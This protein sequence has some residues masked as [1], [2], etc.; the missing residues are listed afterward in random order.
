MK[1]ILFILCLV[2]NISLLAQI[3]TAQALL[4]KLDSELVLNPGVYSGNLIYRDG[5]VDRLTR[6]VKL[7]TNDDKYLWEIKK[8]GENY[9]RFLTDP[10]KEKVYYTKIPP[11]I[12]A[13]PSP[14]EFDEN[15]LSSN[16]SVFDFSAFSFEANFKSEKIFE[17]KPGKV[18][19]WK[20]IAKPIKNFK[21]SRV[22]FLFT[23]SN[24]KIYRMDFFNTNGILNKTVKYKEKDLGQHGKKFIWERESTDPVTGKITILEFTHVAEDP[25]V[26]I[27]LFKKESL[28]RP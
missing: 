17:Y 16:F 12:V 7:Y 8:K 23:K 13:E 24:Q 9:F 6:K 25:M 3:P 26:S 11:N 22:E 5:N 14:E 28:A 19:F 21:Y 20:L 2:L 1:K 10:K 27:N 15:L 18:S 4:A